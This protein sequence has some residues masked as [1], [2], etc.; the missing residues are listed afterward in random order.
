MTEP[1]DFY[2]ECEDGL[3]E[4][5]QSLTDYF[6]EKYQVSDDDSVLAKGTKLTNGASYYAII[7]PGQF[8]DTPAGEKVTRY[9]W[10]VI[11]DFYVRYTNYKQSWKRYKEF[12][13]A[14]I[15]LLKINQTLG[16]TP[17]VERVTFGSG[18]QPAYFNQESEIQRKP[19]F[20]IHTTT[21]TIRQLCFF[22]GG[23][24]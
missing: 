2:Q 24:L 17:G 14:I 8:P 13:N 11:V 23:D 3:V 19:N 16:D 15:H 5:L 12:R 20:I 9:D 21:V 4:T 1:T 22:E 10:E 18:E 7:R 6:P